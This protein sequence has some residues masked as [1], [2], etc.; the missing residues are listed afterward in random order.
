M[1]ATLLRLLLTAQERSGDAAAGLAVADEAIAMCRAGRT[2]EAEARR[3]RAE[4]LRTLS[5]SS[6]ESEAELAR[7]LDVA[8]RQGA[9]LFG[10]RAAASLARHRLDG[11]DRP[12]R[13]E[14]RDILA[15]AL[16][17]VPEATNF[18]EYRD[19]VSV[20]ERL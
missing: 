8:R 15:A 9:A 12:S 10:L 1:S 14:A 13:D 11:G 16:N 20:L 4:F 18:V 17:D 3:L 2:W 7:A 6:S 5:G 19:A